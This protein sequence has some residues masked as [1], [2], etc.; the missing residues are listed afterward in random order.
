MRAFVAMPFS[1]DFDQYWAATQEVSKKHSVELFRVDKHFSFERHIDI[2]IRREIGQA[3][4]LIAVLAG[5]RHREITNPNVAF[6]VGYAQGIGLETVLLAEDAEHLPFDFHQQRAC[7]YHGDIAQFKDGL[8]KEIVLL[9]KML[10]EAYNKEVKNF[11]QEIARCL[12]ITLPSEYRVFREDK[13]YLEETIWYAI[14]YGDKKDFRYAVMLGTP[15][16]LGCWLGNPEIRPRQKEFFREHHDHLRRHLGR[17]IHIDFKERDTGQ[18]GKP[19]DANREEKSGETD[20]AAHLVTAWSREERRN[21]EFIK[22]VLEMPAKKTGTSEALQ[23]A[24]RLSDYVEVFEP[25][26]RE[27]HSKTWE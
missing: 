8:E 20:I 24:L 5:D 4:F 2:A 12:R 15:V 18:P 19:P 26:N 22:E 27:F 25:L 11:T 3:D 23:I 21:Q 9:K 14:C 10:R 17:D 16:T 7:L 13:G 6:E 1:Q